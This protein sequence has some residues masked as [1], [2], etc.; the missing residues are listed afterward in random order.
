MR[1]GIFGGT[2]N[3]IHTGHAIIA[4]HLVQSGVVDQLWLMVSPLNPF[5]Q[6]QEFEVSD[7]QRLR[8][9]E[10]VSRQLDGVV[11]SA[12]EFSMPRPSYTIDT[13]KALSVKFPDDEICLVIGA[14]NWEAFDRWRSADEILANYHIIVYPRLNHEVTIPQHLQDRVTLA[15]APV[16]EISST[17]IRQMIADGH[18]VRYWVPDEVLG[19]I[20]RHGLYRG[21]S[22]TS[23]QQK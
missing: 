8:M 19:Y 13:L 23:T 16:I 21:A 3:P 5:K 10:M 11:T 14:D 18:D 1:I 9:A 20:N 2:F 15:D 12:F 22:S 6:G 17:A 7:S 4:S